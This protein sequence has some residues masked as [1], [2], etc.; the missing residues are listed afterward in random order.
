MP[1]HVRNKARDVLINDVSHYLNKQLNGGLHLE[2]PH[3]LDDVEGGHGVVEGV[4]V[5][6]LSQHGSQINSLA[7]L[8]SLRTP[9][10]VSISRSVTENSSHQYQ[11]ATLCN[12]H[13]G[14]Y[15]DHEYLE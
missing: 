10:L 15:G 2:V 5:P 6:R 14:M 1:I 9:S 11:A 3:E 12:I 8:P 4:R 7:R 13:C